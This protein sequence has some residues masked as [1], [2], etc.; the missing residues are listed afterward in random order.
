MTTTAIRRLRAHRI[1]G[2]LPDRLGDRQRSVLEA[3]LDHGQWYAGCGWVWDTV[4]GTDRVMR[5][6][7]RRGLAE[8]TTGGGYVRYMPAASLAEKMES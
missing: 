7:V 5:S 8:Q 2:N 1:V 3:L 6:L 4:S